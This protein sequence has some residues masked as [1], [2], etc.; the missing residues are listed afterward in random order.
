MTDSILE[1][2]VEEELGSVVFVMDYLQ[3]DFVNARFSAYVWPTVSIGDVSRGFGDP[4]YRDAL[5][6]LITHGVIETEESSEAGLVVRFQLGEVVINPEP[7]DLSG[8]EI[9]MLQIHADAFRDASWA[10][11]RPGE[12]VFASRDWS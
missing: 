9:A 3:L 7:T 12:D 10:V 2:L 6:A 8:P 1:A 5:C 11:W 4:G